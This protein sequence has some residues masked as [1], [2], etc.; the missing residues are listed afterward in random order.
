MKLRPPGLRALL[1]A[2]FWLAQSGCSIP[3]WG[4]QE[5]TATLRATVGARKPVT[6]TLDTEHRDSPVRLAPY[7]LWADAR[8]VAMRQYQVAIV[9]Y[10][11]GDHPS[12][13]NPSI[14]L[15]VGDSATID[16]LKLTLL[17]LSYD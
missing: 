12:L 1:V 9:M 7:W 8:P 2:V 16:S 10:S 15:S 14:S 4:P 17:R 13:Q 11:V 5:Y 6:V 3:G